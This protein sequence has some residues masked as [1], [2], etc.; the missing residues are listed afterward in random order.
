[1]EF[2]KL[3]SSA[4]YNLAT[5]GVMNC[6]LSDL[7]VGA[8]ALAA[9]ELN[10]S[11]GYGY[12]PLLEAIA[13]SKGVDPACVVE[14]AGTSMANHLAMAALF[15]PG[16]EVL[17]EEPT[18]GLI[19]STAR[20]LGAHV[21]RFQRRVED[22][23]ALDPDEVARQLTPKT[24][25]I[26]LTNLHNPSS[27]Q[28]SQESLCAVGQLA[29]GAGARVLVDEVY[30]EVLHHPPVPSSIHLG[31]HFVVTGSLTKGYGLSGLRCGWILAEPALAGRMWRMND[32]FAATPVHVAERL[33]V[34]AFSR[35]DALTQRADA[36]L[37]AN[38]RVLL[39][40][41][42][43]HPAIELTIP[44]HGTTVFPRLRQ[45]QVPGFCSFLRER[46][47]TSVVPGSYFEREEHFRVGLA[48]DSAMTGEGLMRL[49]E[50]LHAWCDVGAPAARGWGI[51]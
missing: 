28:A 42:R 21:R 40:T 10:S 45:G 5:S 14:A 19:V 47:E 26:V 27:V 12:P 25:L 8:D 16:D 9:L 11:D 39:D 49:A 36:L 15:E 22:N 41:L 34:L 35:L 32:L 44:A 18:Y 43:D 4:R 2:S 20:Y 30:Q 29:A 50:A 46:Y 1:M 3:N 7:A 33:S 6:T 24:R 37:A 48:G 17:I 13:S 31:P 38:R 51:A 23:Y